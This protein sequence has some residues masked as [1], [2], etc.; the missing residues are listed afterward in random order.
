MDLQWSGDFI[1]SDPFPPAN[2]FEARLARGSYNVH[3]V[4]ARHHLFTSGCHLRQGWA[5]VLSFRSFQVCAME[6]I[7]GTLFSSPDS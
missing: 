6:N 4:S 5:V 3:H 2:Q 7:I 1:S